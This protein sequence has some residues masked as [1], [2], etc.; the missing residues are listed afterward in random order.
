MDELKTFIEDMWD[1]L[2]GAKHYAQ[3]AM[4]HKTDISRSNM[5]AE[6]ARQELSHFDN[7]HKS[8]AKMIE[9]H[10]AGYADGQTLKAVWEFET[11]RLMDKAVK[12]RTM[13]DMAR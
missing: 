6:M 13:L 12:I 5:Y 3:C 2:N 1:E 8:G 4:K 10:A 7:L 11:D 9:A